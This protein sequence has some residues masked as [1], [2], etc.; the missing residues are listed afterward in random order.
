MVFIP[1]LTNPNQNT[2][3]YNNIQINQVQPQVQSQAE[4]QLIHYLNNLNNLNN[5][6]MNYNLN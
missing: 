3:Y 6:N 1:P 4:Q 2:Q 5:I